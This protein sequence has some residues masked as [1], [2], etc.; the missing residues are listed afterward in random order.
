MSHRVPPAAAL[1]KETNEQNHR[2]GSLD[3]V[4]GERV[5][6]LEVEV[7]FV[8]GVLFTVEILLLVEV[9]FA[10]EPLFVVGVP[11]TVEVPLAAGTS[12]GMRV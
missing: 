6:R 8:V 1:D 4:L 11:F 9:L 10:A 7:V 5:P 12:R 3:K 2:A